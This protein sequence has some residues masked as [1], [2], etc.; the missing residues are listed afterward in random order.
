MVFWESN[1]TPCPLTAIGL[2]P[3]NLPSKSL[4]LSIGFVSPCLEFVFCGLS[5]VYWEATLN[6]NS[7]TSCTPS[8]DKARMLAS[9]TAGATSSPKIVVPK[10]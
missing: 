10:I 8:C 5:E 7:R 6:V 9:A 3:T 4:S 2:K 1:A